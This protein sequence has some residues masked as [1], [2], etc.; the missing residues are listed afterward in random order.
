MSNIRVLVADDQIL[1]R[2]GIRI[3][4]DSQPDIEVVAAAES[5]SDALRLTREHR[6]DVVLLDIQMPDLSGIEVLKS[7]KREH[8]ETIVLMLTTFDPD[9]Y[10]FGAFENGADGYLLKDMSGEK[11]IGMVREAVSGN[12]LIPAPIA[13]RLIARIPREKRR[14]CLSDYNLTARETEIAGLIRSGCSNEKISRLLGIG[15]GT[16]KNYVS[17]LYSKLEVKN[18]QE[19]V[20]MIS[21]LEGNVK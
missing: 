12:I 13:A 17:T 19:A 9:E 7:I 14:L 1:I 4:L 18:R 2:D 15:L 10:I 6:P 20:R 21:S 5:G 16:V 11:L 3:I 8:P